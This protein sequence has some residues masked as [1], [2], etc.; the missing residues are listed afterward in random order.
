MLGCLLH[1]R[2]RGAG[3]GRPARA[4]RALVAHAFCL[5]EGC[6]SP[7]PLLDQYFCISHP[8]RPLSQSESLRPGASLEVRA[9]G[10]SV[11]P[12]PTAHHYSARKEVREVQAGGGTAHQTTNHRAPTFT[13]IFPGHGAGGE[14]QGVARRVPGPRPPCRPLPRPEVGVSGPRAQPGDSPAITVSPY[15]PQQL[16]PRRR[17]TPRRPVSRPAL[18]RPTVRAQ[19]P[20]LPACRLRVAQHGA[21]QLAASTTQVL[22][23]L[24]MAESMNALK[25]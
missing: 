5:H 9:G 8:G 7:L 23:P 21:A 20:A 17:R 19:Y 6:S 11:P 25:V 15:L 14:G 24:A 3:G 10:G 1:L 16:P 22:P 13:A 12:A 4:P 18:A 2:H